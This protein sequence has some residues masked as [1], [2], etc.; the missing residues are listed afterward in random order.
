MRKSRTRYFHSPILR[1]FEERIQLVRIDIV[2]VLDL[3]EHLLDL[4]QR[5][6]RAPQAQIPPASV[7]VALAFPAV[8]ATDGRLL[9][10]IGEEVLDVLVP[11]LYALDLLRRGRVARSGEGGIG[12]RSGGGDDGGGDGRASAGEDIAARGGRVVDGGGGRRDGGW[13]IHSGGSECC[14]VRCHH[15]SESK[16]V[17]ND[18]IEHGGGKSPGPAED[19][20]FKPQ[21]GDGIEDDAR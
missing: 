3:R 15:G 7:G 5:V 2:H 12:G 17:D 14:D 6:G 13:Q 18:L 1:R 4:E 19:E 9:V 10:P 16:A 11:R 8:H 21:Q 20:E